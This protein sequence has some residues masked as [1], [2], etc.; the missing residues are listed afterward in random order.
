MRVCRLIGLVALV[1]LAAL[2]PSASGVPPPTEH[3]P[4][5]LWE[6]SLARATHDVPAFLRLNFGTGDQ[7]SAMRATCR[8]PGGTPGLPEAI[9]EVSWTDSF[10]RLAYSGEMWVSLAAGKGDW[11]IFHGHRAR[12]ACLRAR[13]WHRCGAKAV[14]NLKYLCGLGGKHC[15]PT[16]LNGE[17]ISEPARTALDDLSV[18]GATSWPWM[19]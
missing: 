2:V 8:R 9:C 18:A 4:R 5:T 10:H 16:E 1:V 19:R 7:P 13:D 12:I 6:I 17:P 11:L 14:L 3:A 15:T